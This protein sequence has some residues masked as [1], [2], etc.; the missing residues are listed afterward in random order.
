MARTASETMARTGGG[1]PHHAA[2]TK[3]RRQVATW[4]LNVSQ[5]EI[6]QIITHRPYVKARSLLWQVRRQSQSEALVAD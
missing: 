2:R 6:E 1:G 3:L 5:A 4:N